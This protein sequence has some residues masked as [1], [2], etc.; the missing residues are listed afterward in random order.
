M[1]TYS[2]DLAWN[3][4]MVV[5]HFP[6]QYIILIINYIHMCKYI[7]IMSQMFDGAVDVI[8]SLTLLKA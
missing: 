6:S 3:F 8:K 2:T 5:K 1:L 7:I 4:I